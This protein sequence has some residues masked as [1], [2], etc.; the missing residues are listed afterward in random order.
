MAETEV[1]LA[2][3]Y[4]FIV[5]KLLKLYWYRVSSPSGAEELFERLRWL[6]AYEDRRTETRND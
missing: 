3:E 5:R 4:S 1:D 6:V 2:S